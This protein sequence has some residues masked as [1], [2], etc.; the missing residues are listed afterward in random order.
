MWTIEFY[1]TGSGRCPVQDFLDRLNKQTELPFV[2]NDLDNLAEHGNQ[3][4]R[5]QADILDD[6]I[7][8]LRTR[9]RKKQI[10]CLYFFHNRK[11]IVVTHGFIERE[12]N[13]QQEIKKAKLYRAEYLGREHQ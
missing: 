10:R 6:G 12:N 9:R 7:Y 5:P 13:T 2:L 8:E 3:L 4:T 1:K 11:I